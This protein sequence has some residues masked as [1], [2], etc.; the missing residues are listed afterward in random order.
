MEEN[1]YIFTAWNKETSEMFDD[2]N[3][4]ENSWLKKALLAFQETA[5]TLHTEW[6]DYFVRSALILIWK[7]AN[8]RVM[9]GLNQLNTA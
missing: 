3:D 2:T 8:N 9:N 1:K 4:Q 7:A 5:A 6:A